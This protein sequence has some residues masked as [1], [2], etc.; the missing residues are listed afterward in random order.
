MKTIIKLVLAI[1][2][3]VCLPLRADALNKAELID[4]VAAETNLSKDDSR[5]AIN[6]VIKA[7]VNTLKQ[8]EK[9]QI[10]GFGTFH[11]WKMVKGSGVE[12][13]EVRFEPTADFLQQCLSASPPP[14]VNI[15]ATDKNGTSSDGPVQ[16]YINT[17]TTLSWTSTNATSCKATGGW[18]GSKP[19]AGNE[20]KKL[21]SPQTFTLT[22]TGPGGSA[23]DSVTVNVIATGGSGGGGGG[24][25]RPK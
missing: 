13:N 21:T 16:I 8:K 12:I 1:I 7:F 20:N 10:F 23:S 3:L 5:K 2:C 11:M 17:T 9:V 19:T 14:T 18:S 22:C 25:I 6:A 24:T 15:K 4:A